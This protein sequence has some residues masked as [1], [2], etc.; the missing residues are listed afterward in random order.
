M[1][2]ENA[3]CELQKN[4]F[5]ATMSGNVAVISDLMTDD[6]VF[7]TPGKSPFGKQEFIES[8]NTMKE[9]VTIGCDGV[10]DEITVVGD[11]AYAMARIEIMVAPKNG[12]TAKYLS[13]NTLSIYK[14]SSDGNWRLSRDANLLA[15]RST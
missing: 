1:T 6:V 4:W 15:P 8:F 5:Q 2:D 11:V 14:R 7:L 13:G 12:G 10:Y 9:H 3:I